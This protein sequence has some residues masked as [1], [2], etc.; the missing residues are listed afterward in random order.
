M[1]KVVMLLISLV[2]LT[3]CETKKLTYEEFV[4]KLGEDFQVGDMPFDEKQQPDIEKVAFATNSNFFVFYYDFK[5]DRESKNLYNSYVEDYEKN[6]SAGC[7]QKD[8][9]KARYK[10]YSL[11]C[12]GK[13]SVVI[14]NKDIV[15]TASSNESKK[16]LVDEAIKKLGY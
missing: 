16:D 2:L 14:Q 5:T 1:K 6:K 10:K 13:Y 12:D 4:D 3:G 11:L 8:T 9:S 7:I 15:V